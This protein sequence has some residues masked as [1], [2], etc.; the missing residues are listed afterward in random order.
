MFGVWLGTT[1]DE[2]GGEIMFGGYDKDHV[3]GDISILFLIDMIAWSPVIRKGYWEV[4]LESVKVGK[5]KITLSSKSAAIDTGSSLFAMPTQ[6]AD[7]IN[8]R[9][10][11]TKNQNGQYTVE[12]DMVDSMPN[13]VLVFSGKDFVLE[14]S[15]YI[16]RVGGFFGSKESC[17]SGFMGLDVFFF[18]IH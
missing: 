1:D 6:E 7:E 3:D 10:G 12:C 5:K 8:S 18:N 14:P 13:L 17:I 4:A 11:A 2:E 16:L 9:I 15:D